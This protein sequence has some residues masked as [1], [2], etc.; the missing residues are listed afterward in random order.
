MNDEIKNYIID[1]M[2]LLYHNK[3]IF[4][5]LEGE[6]LPKVKQNLKKQVVSDRAYRVAENFIPPINIIKRLTDKLSSVYVDPPKRMTENSSDQILLDY[7]E[8]EINLGMSEANRFFNSMKSCAIE[9]YLEDM[10][11]VRTISGHLCLARGT[12]SVNPL[13][14]TEFIKFVE[15]KS[16]VYS[17]DG[18]VI[19]DENYNKIQS[20]ENPLGIIPQ[21]YLARSRNLLVPKSDSDLL[22]MGLLLPSMIANLN[23]AAHMQSHSIIYG[24][25]VDSE[26]LELNPDSF[27]NLTS[28]IGGDVPSIGTIKP[29]VDTAEVWNSIYSQLQMWFET[30]GIR[31]G[32][33]TNQSS[34]SG[35][36]MMIKEMDV[37][38]DIKYQLSFFKKYE[39]E[40]LEKLKIQ[41][42][43]WVD[44]GLVDMPRFSE[45]F[46]PQVEFQELK[47]YEDKDKI[48]DREIKML[49]NLLTS[50][51]RARQ[52]IHS[53]LDADQL[54][55][56]EAEINEEFADVSQESYSIQD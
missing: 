10:P 9:F 32:E 2:P 38:S 4:E 21:V 13:R 16:Y 53:A 43:Y 23:Y 28:T 25:N 55:E 14:M 47:S 11:K 5:I 50:R 12:S 37:T 6:L 31:A 24:I 8:E 20:Q 7:Y 42:N 49:N 35:I 52:V 19:L 51:K 41:H 26:N 36:A 30:R 33:S 39:Y 1:H 18:L 34:L 27:W 15:K 40:L 46:M 56:L 22:Q 3:E 45:S 44:A 54:I 48:I 17:D 29:T